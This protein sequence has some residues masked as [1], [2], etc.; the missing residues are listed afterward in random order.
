LQFERWRLN[1]K[2]R[3]L[4]AADKTLKTFNELVA[5]GQIMG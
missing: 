2:I 1:E 3:D 5:N 4:E